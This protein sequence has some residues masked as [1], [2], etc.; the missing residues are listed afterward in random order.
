M[1]C[2]EGIFCPDLKVVEDVYNANLAILREALE[3]IAN[4]KARTI[5]P[6]T[7]EAAADEYAAMLDMDRTEAR[8]ALLRVGKVE[9]PNDRIIRPPK[10][11]SGE[12]RLRYPRK[13][14]EKTCKTC[15]CASVPSD[16]YPCIACLVLCEHGNHWTPAT[17][18]EI[19]ADKK[20]VDIKDK[21]NEELW[22]GKPRY[23]SILMDRKP[24]PLDMITGEE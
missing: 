13:P 12:N 6:W 24:K 2:P 5:L 21:P 7:H 22:E 15:T 16:E 4:R 10:G 18:E 19:A 9:E 1:S 23:V 8:D 14:E 11:G 20:M 17:E 3:R